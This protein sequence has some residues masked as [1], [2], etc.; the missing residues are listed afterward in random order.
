[1]MTDKEL[2]F[3]G[4]VAPVKLLSRREGGRC[5]KLLFGHFK[6]IGASLQIVLQRSPRN[7]KV[8]LTEAEETAEGQNCVC[9][10]AGELVDHH[11]LDHA[12][13]FAVGRQTGVPSTRS[14]A[15]KL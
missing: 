14:L 4:P 6:F 15:I 7:G 11:A 12:D 10:L 3:V 9:N 5:A 13:L 8:L 2:N 1:M